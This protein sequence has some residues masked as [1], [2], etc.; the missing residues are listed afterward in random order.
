MGGAH[1]YSGYGE[2]SPV[3]NFQL[4]AWIENGWQPIA[5][6]KHSGNQHTAIAIP[7]GQSV[8]TRKIRLVSMDEGAH[9]R[10]RAATLARTT[11]GNSATI[12]RNS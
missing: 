2:S 10:E 3:R 9:A 11:S 4:L 5:G 1:L 12:H 7:F 8:T 6:S